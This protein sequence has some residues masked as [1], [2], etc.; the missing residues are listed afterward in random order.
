MTQKESYT[1][2]YIYGYLSALL[3]AHATEYDRSGFKTQ[4][5]AMY[6]RRAFAQ[7]HTAAMDKGIITQEVTR[8]LA[9]LID[10]INSIEEGPEPCQPLDMQ[11]SWQM[12]YYHGNSGKPY[13]DSPDVAVLRKAKGLTQKQLAEM[14]GC[15]QAIISRA[16]SGKGSEEWLKKILAA[17]K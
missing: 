2:G 9:A 15:D 6:P 7:I 1:Y 3:T 13:P 5:G 11:G 12:G 10:N 17:L 14:V 8:K 4:Q 16:E